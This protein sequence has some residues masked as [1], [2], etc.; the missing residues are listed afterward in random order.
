MKTLF[1][2]SK[3]NCWCDIYYFICSC[4][5]RIINLS[6]GWFDIQFV[7]LRSSSSR[8]VTHTRHMHAYIYIVHTLLTSS[9]LSTFVTFYIL[10]NLYLLESDEG[11]SL[12][13]FPNSQKETSSLFIELSF[14]LLLLFA[15]FVVGELNCVQCIN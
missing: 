15:L 13:V 8:E 9:S 4:E 10:I 1:S 14:L 7:R 3:L 12:E 6:L 2:G 11:M 5:M